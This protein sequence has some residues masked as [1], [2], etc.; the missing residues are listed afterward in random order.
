[1]NG[2]SEAQRCPA[3]A[4]ELESTKMTKSAK[5]KHSRAAAA[6]GKVSNAA[7]ELAGR[8]LLSLSDFST[9]QVAAVL[10]LA[11]SMKKSPHKH[12]D[13]LRGQSCI[14]LFEKPSLRTRISFE[15]GIAKLGGHCIYMDHSTQRLG[16][17]ESVHDYGKNLERWVN[18]IIPRVF[19]HATLTKMAAASSVPVVN[20][21]CDMHHPCQALA[22]MLTLRERF[23]SLKGLKVAYIGDGNNVCH[24]LMHA[25]VLNGAWVV[26]VTPKGF[27][28]SVAIVQECH[29][30]AKATG[31]V[32]TVT[33]SLDGITDAD[34]VYTDVWASMGTSQDEAGRRMKTFA[35]YQVNA[36]LMGRAGKNAVFMHCLPAHRGV[37]VTDDV[38]DGAASVV[39]QQAE[40]R[41]WAQMALLALILKH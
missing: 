18:C 34:A 16:Q 33:N 26:A 40:N 12:R 13:V 7:K 2:Q 27:E 20:A 28:P 4:K 17:R 1:M 41:M 10:D 9:R 36:A 29:D 38:L 35:K 30:I 19:E 24:S 15:V 14:L 23:G 31:A 8:D 37:E 32:V 39:Y 21:L 6:K 3:Y 25:C 11:L 5:S 22:D